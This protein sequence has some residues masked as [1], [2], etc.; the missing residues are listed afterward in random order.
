VAQDAPPREPEL[1][2]EGAV[3]L[4]DAAGFAAYRWCGFNVQI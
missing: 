3:V 4:L 2:G 1:A